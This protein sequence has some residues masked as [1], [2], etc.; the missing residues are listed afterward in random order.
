MTQKPGPGNALGQVKFE[1]PNP[2]TIYLHDTPS[3]ELFDRDARA[4]SHGCIRLDRP[5]DLAET[6]LVDRPDWAR[7]SID[8]AVMRGATV[9][10]PLTAHLPIYV[11]YFTMMPE[12]DGQVTRLPDVYARNA[13]VIAAL[14]APHP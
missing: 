1:M 6:L 4:F 8:A 5:L 14:K 7:P 3:K 10:A 11:V 2:N 12:A 9:T 13:S